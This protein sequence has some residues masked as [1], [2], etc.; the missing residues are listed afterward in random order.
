MMNAPPGAASG[1][2]AEEI[3]CFRCDTM[4]DIRFV[5]ADPEGHPLCNKCYYKL[6]NLHKKSNEDLR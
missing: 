3:K 5:F 1:G 4:T 2:M 6:V